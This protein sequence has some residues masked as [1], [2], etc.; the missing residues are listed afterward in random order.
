MDLIEEGKSRVSSDDI[1]SPSISSSSDREMDKN[2]ASTPAH[3]AYAYL[4]G[5]NSTNATCK[6]SET[7]RLDQILQLA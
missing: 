7:T 4:S 2:V 6:L 3:K 1:F 5:N